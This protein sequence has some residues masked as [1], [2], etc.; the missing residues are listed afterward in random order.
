MSQNL[1]ETEELIGLI[2]QA[3][4]VAATQG[5]M[6]TFTFEIIGR[7]EIKHNIIRFTCEPYSLESENGLHL[8]S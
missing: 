2:F 8:S 5:R 7:G 3:M 6:S 4:E 1:T